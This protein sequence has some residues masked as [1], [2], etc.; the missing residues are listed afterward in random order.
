MIE[1]SILFPM[2]ADALYIVCGVYSMYGPL[3]ALFA[4]AV[5][6]LLTYSVTYQWRLFVDYFPFRR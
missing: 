2:S 5:L 4:Y 3:S 1:N 6:V